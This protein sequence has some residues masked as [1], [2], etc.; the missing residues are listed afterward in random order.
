MEACSH[1]DIVLYP[2]IYLLSNASAS[3]Y[4]F[5]DLLKQNLHGKARYLLLLQK[6]LQNYGVEATTT[7][8]LGFKMK[9]ISGH[10]YIYK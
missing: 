1:P 8:L 3:S 5:A 7:Q 4:R 2:T 6:N 10:L 9:N